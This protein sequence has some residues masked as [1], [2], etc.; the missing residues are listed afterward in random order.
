MRIKTRF[1]W[2]V[3]TAVTTTM[4]LVTGTKSLLSRVYSRITPTTMPKTRKK[5][6]VTH[7]KTGMTRSTRNLKRRSLNPRPL[8]NSVGYALKSM[9]TKRES[10]R[11]WTPGARSSPNTTPVV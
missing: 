5:R 6:I 10:P 4:T 1:C 8:A 2:K 9:R 7:S 3:P 11:T